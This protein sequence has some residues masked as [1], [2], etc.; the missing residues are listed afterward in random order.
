M[1]NA[2]KKN[3]ACFCAI[4]VSMCISPL[5]CRG[6][7]NAVQQLMILQYRA[8]Q[9]VSTADDALVQTALKVADAVV[10]FKRKTNRFPASWNEV[11]VLF[12]IRPTRNPYLQDDMLRTQLSTQQAN[13]NDRVNELVDIRVFSDVAV[14]PASIEHFRRFPPK[15]W[16]FPAGTITIIHNTENQFVIWCA[17]FDGLPIREKGKDRILLIARDLSQQYQ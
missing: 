3:S 15:D 16:K 1:G 4:T 14:S 5:D 6:Q 13:T 7:D 9:A 10:A 17:G 12:P 8:E 2:I 11:A